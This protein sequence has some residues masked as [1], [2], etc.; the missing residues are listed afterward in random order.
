METRHLDVV[1]VGA[2][3]SGIAAAYYLQEQ[4]PEISFTVLEARDAIGG[5]WDLFRYPGI[6]SDSDMHSLGF[7]FHPWRSDVALADAESILEYLHDTIETF[8]LGRYF[9]MRRRVVEAAWSSETSR[10][11]LT[12]ETPEGQTEMTCNFLWGCTGYYDYE[13]GHDP[14]FEGRDEFEGEIVHPQHWPEELDYAGKRVVV[15]GSGA[16][17]VTVVPAM[18][19]EA[20]HVTMLQRSPSYVMSLPGKDATAERLQSLFGDR[21]GARIARWKNVLVMMFFYNLSRTLPDVVRRHIRTGVVHELG[22]EVA[23]EHFSPSYDPW[24]QRICFVPDSDLFEAIREGSASV[25][26]DHIERFTPTGILLRSGEEIEADIVVTATGLRLVF[27]G[28]A[29]VVV[30]G[31]P[32]NTGDRYLHKGTMLSDLPNSAMSIGYTNAAWTLKCELISQYVVRL[33]KHM[34]RNGYTQVWPRLPEDLEPQPLI[35][36]TSG[37]VERASAVLPRQ[38]DRLPWRLYQNYL[39]DWLLYRRGKIDDG[40]EF[41]RPEG[42]A[43]TRT[44]G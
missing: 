37:Y 18:A 5:T 21:R 29:R 22:P 15:I 9:E 26:T 44:P 23:D 10:W 32:V 14:E 43:G 38:G 41:V 4:C 12:V 6:R 17:A 7:S 3:L 28:N 19:K 40:L 33:L 8:D 36:F 39:L 24:D 25:V 20:A 27:M 16:T 35:D 31:E 13:R 2:G 11:T 30:D 42:E 34:K 1:V